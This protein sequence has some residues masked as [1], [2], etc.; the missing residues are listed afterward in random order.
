MPQ[1]GL[2]GDPPPPASIAGPEKPE[3]PAPAGWI[4]GTNQPH[5]AGPPGTSPVWQLGASSLE[6]KGITPF[7]YSVNDFLTFVFMFKHECLS[8]HGLGTSLLQGALL[9]PSV[10]QGDTPGALGASSSASK[11]AVRMAASCSSAGQLW[12]YNA[13]SHP[14]SLF[15]NTVPSRS[16]PI[17]P[18]PLPVCPSLL[19]HNQ[20]SQCQ[21]A[22]HGL[23]MPLPGSAIVWSLSCFSLCG[24]LP[25]QEALS[26][27][28]PGTTGSCFPP[29]PS[30]SQLA[31]QPA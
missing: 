4:L 30:S 1:E 14:K 26:V 21:R 19:P 5:P 20:Y 16:W 22:L 13:H 7:F 2:V 8:V 9:G 31:F 6:A 18:P 11:E 15:P 29:V 17:C 25:E 12:P 23:R 3:F 10:L 28:P 24:S 27:A